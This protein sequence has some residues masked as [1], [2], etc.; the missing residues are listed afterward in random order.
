MLHV[1][2][3]ELDARCRDLRA[4]SEGGGTSDRRRGTAPGQ[5]LKKR[6][7]VPAPLS[8]VAGTIDSGRPEAPG[9]VNDRPG[10]ADQPLQRNRILQRSLDELGVDPRDPTRVF[11]KPNQDSRTETSRAQGV[12]QV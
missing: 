3:S 11:E 4:S 1:G 8:G 5:D 6:S 9:E 7:R 2:N 12:D 10:S